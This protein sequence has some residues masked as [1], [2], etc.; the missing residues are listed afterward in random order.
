MLN[1]AF[2]QLTVIDTNFQI[3]TAANGTVNKVD[4]QKS[5]KIILSGDFQSF[6]GTSHK[7][8]VR[9]L[10]D[11]SLDGSFLTGTGSEGPIRATAL[12]ADDKLI[13]GGLFNFYNSKAVKN[14]TRLNADGT[15]DTTFITGSGANNEITEIFIQ[16]DDRIIISGFFSK[17]NNIIFPGFARLNSNGTIDTNFNIGTGTNLAPECFAQQNNGKLLV[18]GSF[19]RYKGLNVSKIIRLDLNGNLDT[20]FIAGNIAGTV[21]EVIALPDNKIII[22][23]SFTAINGKFAGRMARL[24]SDGSLDTT[25]FANVSGRIRDMHLQKDGKIII[26]G[27]F[28]TVN[29][30]SVQ[31]IARL[32][33][34]GSLDNTVYVG[35]NGTV[36]D[37]AE[38]SDKNVL[39]SGSFTQLTQ[40][41]APLT[42]TINRIARLENNYSILQPCISATAPILDSSLTNF[43]CINDVVTLSVIGGNLNSGSN[44]FWYKDSLNGSLVD[45]GSSITVYGTKSTD[46]YVTAGLT[47]SDTVAKFAVYKLFVSEPINTE[48]GVDSNGMYAH[49]TTCTYQWY[50]CDSSLIPIQGENSKWFLPK[51]T[52]TYML[53]LT[54]QYGCKAFSECMN[55]TVSI[56]SVYQTK[57]LNIQNPVSN[58]IQIP[59]QYQLSE[60]EIFSSLGQKVYSG[61]KDLGI[62]DISA[63]KSGV[64][65]LR[66]KNQQNI[67]Y[68]EKLMILN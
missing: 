32:N 29:G 50:V 56:L 42:K 18:G 30:Q 52:G 41:V 35:T 20:T 12:Q 3:G 43:V 9:L 26:A 47:C 27:D 17:Y 63:L 39:I 8:I 44:W 4:I 66:A 34:N 6:K 7:R 36:Y 37:I 1:D 22:S 65:Y 48:I 45:S 61:T 59:I 28:T 49:D 55:Y 23:G 14:I 19:L 10:P 53:E 5:G 46:F 13:I 68:A 58:F 38:Q 62:I 31:R 51:T 57:P 54:N 21:N 25:F 16:K 64:Y 60:L 67:I 11:G 33:P 40:S 24:F 15:L 2:A